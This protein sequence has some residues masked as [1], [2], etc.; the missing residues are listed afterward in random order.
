MITRQVKL[1]K[2]STNSITPFMGNKTKDGNMDSL[3]LA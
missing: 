3:S 2:P 1:Q